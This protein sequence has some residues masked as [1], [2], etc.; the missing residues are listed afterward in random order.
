MIAP[1]VALSLIPVMTAVG[2]AVDYSRANNIRSK[3]QSALDSALLA[4]AKEGS[5]VWNQIAID[6][7]DA[8]F[9]A[10]LANGLIVTK[11]FAQDSAQRLSRD[12][13][14]FGPD[15]FSGSDPGSEAER[16]S[17]GRRD[18]Q[19]AGQLMHPDTR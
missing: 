2:A 8:N 5:S 13:F 12:R 15:R 3:L 10:T 16:E 18:R 19:R 1:V 17:L 6:N 11:N 14:R 4:A 9:R 7:F